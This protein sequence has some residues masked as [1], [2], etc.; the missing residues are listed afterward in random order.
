MDLN[1]KSVRSD[2][3][4]MLYTDFCRRKNKIIKILYRIYLLGGILRVL[5]FFLFINSARRILSLY[6][7]DE[8]RFLPPKVQISAT[9]SN[10]DRDPVLKCTV[11]MLITSTTNQRFKLMISSSLES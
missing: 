4:T 10:T 8:N 9:S 1:F 3:V 6:L 5:I 11:D 2:S 7:G